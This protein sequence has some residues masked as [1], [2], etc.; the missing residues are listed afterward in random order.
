MRT[1]KSER[2]KRTFDLFRMIAGEMYRDYMTV[3]PAPSV[4]LVAVEDFSD[5]KGHVHTTIT[6]TAFS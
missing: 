5:E 3:Y 1:M 2:K 6:R 4:I